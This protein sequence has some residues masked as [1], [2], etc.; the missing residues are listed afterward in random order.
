MKHMKQI[1]SVFV[2]AAIPNM[3]HTFKSTNGLFVESVG[4]VVFE[5]SDWEDLRASAIWCAAANYAIRAQKAGW[6]TDLYIVRSIAPST[7]SNN[8]FSVRFSTDPAAS[9]VSSAGP[10]SSM[11]EFLVG[12]HMPIQQANALCDFQSIFS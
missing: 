10:G 3:G 9:G 4:G 7:T 1:L 6:Q 5:V 8:G 11:G 12:D 2:I